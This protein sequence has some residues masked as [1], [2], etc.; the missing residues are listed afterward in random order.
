[1]IEDAEFKAG[2]E[3]IKGRTAYMNQ[4]DFKALIDAECESY[5]VR[6]EKL[7]VRQ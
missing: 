6:A 2:L 4:A 3:N 1:M 5:T 7:G